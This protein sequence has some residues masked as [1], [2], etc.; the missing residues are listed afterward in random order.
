MDLDAVLFD[1]QNDAVLLIGMETEAHAPF[2]YATVPVT[3]GILVSGAL[4]NGT[5]G[6]VY[7]PYLN[8]L[9]LGRETLVNF[10]DLITKIYIVQSSGVFAVFIPEKT[11][12]SRRL[13]SV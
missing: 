3:D 12:K 6:R 9:Y 7:L 2:V 1:A 8:G 13:N 5:A 10:G 11:Q 4:I